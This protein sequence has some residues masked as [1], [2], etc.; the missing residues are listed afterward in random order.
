MRYCKI[1]C[2]MSVLLLLLTACEKKVR[3]QTDSDGFVIYCLDTSTV[4]LQSRVYKMKAETV[5]GQV[6]ECLKQ[7]QREPADLT[8]IK[9]LPD[10]TKLLDYYWHDEG[11][12]VLNFDA[13]YRE[14]K[15][16]TEILRRAAIVKTL[17]QIDG[18]DYVQFEVAGQPIT[19][20]NETAIGMMSA[21]DFIDST[22]GDDAG[23]QSSKLSVY[24]ANTSGDGL[25]QIPIEITYDSAVSIEKLVLEQLIEGPYSIDGVEKSK[26]LPTVP[27][28][29]KLLKVS[30][31]ES[32]CYVDFSK[33]FLEKDAKIS[34]EVAIYSVVN[35]LVELPNINKVRFSIEGASTAYYNEIMVFDE[36]FE[37]DLD[38]VENI[39]H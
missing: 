37:R 12:L 15:G 13:G 33:E 3:T 14:E 32:V 30:V 23:M 35:S 21:A 26:V 24:F 10:T 31:K 28:G 38:L 22:G 9:A 27:K 20:S 29:T 18:V 17:C 19:D 25:V 2:M 4:K 34:S 16:T 5:E 39:L 36:P 1:I 8:F 7:L 11:E 6:K